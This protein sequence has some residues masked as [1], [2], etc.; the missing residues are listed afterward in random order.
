MRTLNGP[1]QETVGRP[2]S[3]SATERGINVPRAV[4]ALT[5]PATRDRRGENPAQRRSCSSACGQGHRVRSRHA[6]QLRD[7]GY[8]LACDFGIG[9]PLA[10]CSTGANQI[11]SVAMSDIDTE[12]KPPVP[13]K[14][15]KAW[16]EGYRAGR[17]GLAAG[18][19]PYPLGTTEA[20]T[21]RSGLFVGRRKRLGV[22]GRGPM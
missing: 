3:Y 20:V 19:N 1:L 8:C 16:H 2:K 4:Q 13:L 17:R 18:A 5:R 6:A 7:Y 11:I 22:V 9:A 14:D 15:R 10:R 21:W 12:E